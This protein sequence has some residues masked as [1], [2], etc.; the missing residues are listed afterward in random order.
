MLACIFAIG[1]AQ[2][3][4]L[5]NLIGSVNCSLLIAYAEKLK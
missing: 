3:E 2:L 5:K 4:L 1:I